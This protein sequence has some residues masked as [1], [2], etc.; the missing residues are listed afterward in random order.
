ML[1]PLHVTAHGVH[2]S[3]G[4]LSHVIVQSDGADN[5]GAAGLLVQLLSF[6]HWKCVAK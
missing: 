3:V 5:V 4:V 2:V 6:F 1:A